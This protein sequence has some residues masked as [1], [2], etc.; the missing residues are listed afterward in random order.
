[1]S[2][3]ELEP[4]RA[5]YEKFKPENPVDQN[6][7]LF[8]SWPDI[9]RSQELSYEQHMQIVQDARRK[10]VET[11][12]SSQALS[13]V[14]SIAEKVE[15]PEE[16]GLALSRIEMEKIRKLI[17]YATLSVWSR[18]KVRYPHFS[19]WLGVISLECIDSTAPFG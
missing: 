19:E 7:W 9:P 3:Q 18:R 4:L 11:I 1:M 12:Y 2:G 13:G 17:S 10:A 8:T 15:R 16:I 5:L 6:T 14:Y